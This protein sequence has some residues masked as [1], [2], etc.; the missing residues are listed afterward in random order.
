MFDLFH[1]Y[2]IFSNDFFR[3][4][5]YHL[6]TFLVSFLAFHFVPSTFYLGF[7][8]MFLCV[9]FLIVSP[10]PVVISMHCHSI[11]MEWLHVVLLF[12]IFLFK[13]ITW[14]YWFALYQGDCS[15]ELQPTTR[16][17]FSVFWITPRFKRNII[18]YVYLLFLPWLC[19]LGSTKPVIYITDVFLWFFHWMF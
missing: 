10:V 15:S 9:L 13:I 19:S 8:Y 5:N 12:D 4:F 7:W 11:I 6:D 3:G 16:Y 1:Q 2:Y 17:T 14:S 18:P